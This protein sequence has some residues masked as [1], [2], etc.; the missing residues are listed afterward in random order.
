MLCV[1]QSISVLGTSTC[2]PRRI[3]VADAVTC[4]A[5]SHSRLCR[6]ERCWPEPEAWLLPVESSATARPAPTPSDG[7]GVGDPNPFHRSAV[8]AWTENAALNQWGK[9]CSFHLP[10]FE[11]AIKSNLVFLYFYRI[12]L[13]AEFSLS[14]FFFCVFIKKGLCFSLISFT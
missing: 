7:R 1:C 9:T 13:K 14:C 8:C 4:T 10:T 5:W 2:F 6:A 12:D 11:V 3:S